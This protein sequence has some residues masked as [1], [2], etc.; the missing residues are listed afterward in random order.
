MRMNW[1]GWI[2]AGRAGVEGIRATCSRNLYLPDLSELSVLYALPICW[3]VAAAHAQRYGQV[4]QTELHE[5]TPRPYDHPVSM[6]RCAVSTKAQQQA[7]RCFSKG[8]KFPAREGIDLLQ[9]PRYLHYDFPIGV[10]QR[11]HKLITSRISRKYTHKW[12]WFNLVL[13]S[14]L[15]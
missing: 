4:V 11:L 13:H 7:R 2:K 6:V 12:V 15:L 1:G 3:Q 10:S 5:G 9:N 14:S 8:R